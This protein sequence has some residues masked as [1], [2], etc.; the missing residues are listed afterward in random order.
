MSTD[1]SSFCRSSKRVKVSNFSL[2]ELSLYIGYNE[3]D[4]DVCQQCMGA[5][6]N[7]YS[8]VSDVTYEGASSMLFQYILFFWGGVLIIIISEQ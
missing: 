8:A 2:I 7:D 5:I 1:T 6:N 3:K 4:Q